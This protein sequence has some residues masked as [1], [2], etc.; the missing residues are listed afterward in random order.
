[1]ASPDQAGNTQYL[2]LDLRHRPL[3]RRKIGFQ[4]RHEA[5]IATMQKASCWSPV[6]AF[7]RE[8]AAPQ[9]RIDLSDGGA[10]G[11][12]VPAVERPEMHAR[13]ERIR[14]AE[15]AV[16]WPQVTDAGLIFIGCVCTPWTSRMD[17]PRHGRQDGPICRI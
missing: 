9:R 2:A 15:R 14:V 5:A 1:L 7:E 3:G 10:P 11:R 6:W 17:C 13:P 8:A 4:E 16:E 12:N